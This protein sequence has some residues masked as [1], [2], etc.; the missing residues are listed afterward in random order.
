MKEQYQSIPSTVNNYSRV[1]EIV[2][3][4][5]LEILK[6]PSDVI[7]CRIHSRNVLLRAQSCDFRSFS[8]TPTHL[9]LFD[10]PTI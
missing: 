1:V 6:I 5:V 3:A 9:E 10:V 7:G 2:T 4:H 8:Q